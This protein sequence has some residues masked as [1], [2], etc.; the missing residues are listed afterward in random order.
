MKTIRSQRR[1]TLDEAGYEVHNLGMETAILRD[2]DTGKL[3]LFVKN[4]DY[5]GWVVEIN[6]VGYE[7]VSSNC[8]S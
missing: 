3:E 6:G 1:I 2:K 8:L 7:F 5:A 4:D